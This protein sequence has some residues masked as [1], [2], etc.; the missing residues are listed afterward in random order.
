[1]STNSNFDRISE[2]WLA[3]G[4]TQLADRV[5]DAAL[6]E[7]HLTRQRR[8]LP[9]LWRI[10]PMPVQVR[11]AAAAVIGVLLVGIV[12]L[13]L[14]G[15]N[16]VGGAP[17]PTPSPSASTTPD[18]LDVS[19][20]T[21]F[22]SSRYGF[23]ARYPATFEAVPSY[24]PWRIPNFTGNMFDGF[25]SAGVV[26]WLFGASMALPAGMT[27]EAWL[28]AY[29]RDIVEDESPLEPEACFEPRESWTPV[30]IDGRAAEL[31]VGCQTLEAY[32]FVDDRVYLFGASAYDSAVP[33]T[34]ELGVPDEF[35]DL[36]ERWLTTI[37]LDPAS[38]AD[39]SPVPS[40]SSS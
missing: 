34:A 11:L 38:A 3:E 12:Y 29:R 28:D 17:S 24:I 37:T 40:P 14:P 13:N 31:R 15:R 20:W 10:T 18:L 2:A 1:M 8:R 21:T 36:L 35:R 27:Q 30:T 26:K 25:N 9:V 7:V 39:Q 33:S 32:L 19:T 6:D 16:D 4:P 23:S 5:F 22:T